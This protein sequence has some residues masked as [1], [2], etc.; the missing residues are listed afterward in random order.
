MSQNCGSVRFFLS[1]DHWATVMKQVAQNYKTGELALLEVPVPS[2]RPGG[3]LVRSAS[4]LVSAGAEMMKLAES[5]LSL[6]GKAQA[7]PDHVR[8][9]LH[10]IRLNWPPFRP[11]TWHEQGGLGISPSTGLC[12]TST[13]ASR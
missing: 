10:S 7:R 1:H 4:S 12:R 8:K 11:D 6:V 13:V 3:V 5:R 2:C 9:V